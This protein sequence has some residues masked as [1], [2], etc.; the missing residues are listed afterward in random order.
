MG[1]RSNKI[2]TVQP[3]IIGCWSGHQK[4]SLEQIARK[5]NFSWNSL[6]LSRTH[7]SEERARSSILRSPCGGK[8][9]KM[10]AR[11]LK[12]WAWGSMFRRPRWGQ[13][14]KSTNTLVPHWIEGALQRFSKILALTEIWLHTTLKPVGAPSNLEYA[15]KTEGHY[16]S[17]LKFLKGSWKNLAQ[18]KT[19]QICKAHASRSPQ[20]RFTSF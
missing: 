12:E 3:P 17:K 5:F 6:Q 8:L 4:E 20:C 13:H 11:K 9:G 15:T 7:K 18:N 16:T 2:K 10:G 14:N 19:A 1:M